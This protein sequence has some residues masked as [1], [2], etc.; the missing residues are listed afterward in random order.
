MVARL[1]GAPGALINLGHCNQISANRPTPARQ[2]RAPRW[3]GWEPR[4]QHGARD[5][6][7]FA[8]LVDAVARGLIAT[9]A[10]CPQVARS[11]ARPVRT[12]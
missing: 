1:L 6:E 3:A 10:R 8:G 7:E 2:E 4:R 9:V 11:N 5:A 12:R